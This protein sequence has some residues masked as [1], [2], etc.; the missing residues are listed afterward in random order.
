MPPEQLRNYRY[1][2][3]PSDLYS[4]GVTLYYLLTG[5]YIFEYPSPLDLLMASLEGKKI[6][7]NQYEDPLLMILGT[8]PIPVEKYI[9]HIPDRLARIVNKSI[10]KNEQDR[11]LSARE[12][13]EDIR[14]AIGTS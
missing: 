3:P 6:D 14:R 7:L 13:R 4:M 12:F 1:V 11:Y 9:P 2:K 10:M 5:K 8:D